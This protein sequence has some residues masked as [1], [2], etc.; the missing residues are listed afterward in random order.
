M[1]NRSAAKHIL[2]GALME[3]PKHGYQIRQ[4]L[5][6]SLESKW[7]IGNSQMYSLLKRFEQRQWVASSVRLQEKRPARRVYRL[8]EKGEELFLHWMESP[9]LQ[10]RNLRVEVIAKLFYAKALSLDCGEMIVQRQIEAL[11]GFRA[12]IQQ[13]LAK[14]TI[15]FERL[16]LDF[17]LAMIEASIHWLK[18][19]AHDF[20]ARGR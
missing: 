5:D 3:E 13:A 17:R 11:A 8:T 2:L 10:V 12:S 4:F 18:T 19:S 15:P 14:E 20:V 6:R 1:Q 16:S 7:H 9:V